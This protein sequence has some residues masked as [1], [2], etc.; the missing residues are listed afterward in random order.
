MKTEPSSQNGTFRT[1][2]TTSV[3]YVYE[4]EA[5]T[6]HFEVNFLPL[7]CDNPNRVVTKLIC[8]FSD[9]DSLFV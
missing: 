1:I 4:I 2:L 7:S 9:H 6:Y 5:Q 8:C 3:V